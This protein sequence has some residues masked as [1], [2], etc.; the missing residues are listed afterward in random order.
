MGLRELEDAY[1]LR[2]REFDESVAPDVRLE[3]GHR[4]VSQRVGSGKR[5]R[6]PT[7]GDEGEA[8]AQRP[9]LDDAFPLVNHGLDGSAT[10][11]PDGPGKPPLE[12]GSPEAQ[13]THAREPGHPGPGR[14]PPSDQTA[15]SS[16]AGGVRAP[17]HRP[18]VAAAARKPVEDEGWPF[19]QQLIQAQE[20]DP[21]VTE[22]AWK[23][24]R[25]RRQWK[26]GDDGILRYSGRIYVAMAAS[27]RLASA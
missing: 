2:E 16:L 9:R 21:W 6:E 24:A 11:G 1:E 18:Y 5:H 17:D 26:L 22:G 3:E 14:R 19:E 25:M 15:R 4:E 13:E 7:A 8:A 23:T 12:R 10:R 27:G 20:V